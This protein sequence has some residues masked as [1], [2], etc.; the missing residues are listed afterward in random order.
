MGSEMCIRDSIIFSDR[1]STMRLTVSFSAW[2]VRM[3]MTSCIPCQ[4]S[5]A[6]QSLVKGGTRFLGQSCCSGIEVGTAT[7]D[8]DVGWV[9]IIK[10]N[11]SDLDCRW[12]GSGKNDSWIIGGEF[13]VS[14]GD[15]SSVVIGERSYRGSRQSSK[16]ARLLAAKAA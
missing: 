5:L 15:G 9:V 6:D 12:G 8:G 2:I 4:Y 14:A 10:Q 13:A 3:A 1:G 16:A 11:H 7:E